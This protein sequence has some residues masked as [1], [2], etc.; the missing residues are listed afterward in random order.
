MTIA[1]SSTK[2]QLI[3]HIAALDARILNGAR[4]VR[5]LREQI[6]MQPAPTRSEAPTVHKAYY[7]YVRAQRVIAK[8]QGTRVVTFKTFAQWIAA[9]QNNIVAVLDARILNSECIVRDLREQT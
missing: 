3:A 2:A 1:S 7:D 9:A 6:A 4:M 5:D 8:A